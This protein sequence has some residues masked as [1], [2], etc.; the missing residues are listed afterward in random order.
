MGSREVVVGRGF[1]A[2]ELIEHYKGEGLNA[3]W[4]EGSAAKLARERRGFIKD[5][6]KKRLGREATPKEVNT[7]I[8][9]RIMA[10][11]KEEII[12]AVNES[13]Q[14]VVAWSELPSLLREIA[15]GFEKTQ[16]LQDLYDAL[17]VWG[18]QPG[19]S[20]ALKKGKR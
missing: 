19:E 14:G 1:T 9:N 12:L 5:G 2:K 15:D 17:L 11:L 6:L 13:S 20:S 4:E 7:Q 10:A 3:S 8:R 16:T 18:K